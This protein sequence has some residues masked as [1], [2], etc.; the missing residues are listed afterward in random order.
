MRCPRCLN[1]D[2]TYFYRGSRG[3]YCRKCI[4]FGRMMLEE[5]NRPVSLS[6]V[7][8]GSEEYELKYPLT[9]AQA[10]TASLCA[11]L[12]D[13]TDI[14][15]HCVCGAGKTELV[16]QTIAKMLKQRKRVCFAIPRR[17]VVLELRERLASYFPNARTIAVCGGH[18]DVTDGDLIICT[19]HQLYRYY[20]AFDLLILDEPDAFPFRGNA[21]LHGI[22]ETAC[23]GRKIYLTATPDETMKQQIEKGTLKELKLTQRPHGHPLP[24]PVIRTGPLFLQL[25]RLILWLKERDTPRMVFVPTVKEA[26]VMYLVLRLFFSCQYVT[27][28]KADRDRVIESFRKKKSGILIATTVMERGITV[29]RVDI[30]VFRADHSVF[31]E[32]S[33]IQM[34][35]RAGRTFQYP[36]GDVLFLQMSRSALTQTCRDTIREENRCAV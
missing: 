30:C 4:S 14:L 28:Q 12:I 11:S 17:Q 8:E 6:P 25:I 20:Q 1:T 5:A 24:V 10:K 3:W 35:G 33:L 31:D 19:T 13:S 16:V 9:P 27:S 23:R 21:V 18:T 34:A 36:D 26:R 32:A 7:A 2:R 22:A 29:P 15:L